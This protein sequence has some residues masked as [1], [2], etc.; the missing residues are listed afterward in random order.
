MADS[1]ELLSGSFQTGIHLGNKQKFTSEFPV[2]LAFPL[3]YTLQVGRRGQSPCKGQ[4]VPDRVS[5]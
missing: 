1:I 5:L 3:C 4:Q 2:E